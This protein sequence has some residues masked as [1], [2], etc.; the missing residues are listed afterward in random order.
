MPDYQPILFPMWSEKLIYV[1]NLTEPSADAHFSCSAG[2]GNLPRLVG[3]ATACES[4]LPQPRN[5]FDAAIG[6]VRDLGTIFREA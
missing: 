3:V 5:Q 4:R 1:G 6:I 2:T